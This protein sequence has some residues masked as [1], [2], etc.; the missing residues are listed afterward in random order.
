MRYCYFLFLLIALSISNGTCYAIIPGEK[1]T[2]SLDILLN[3]TQNPQKQVEGLLDLTKKNK[4]SYP[5]KAM[6]YAQHACDIAVKNHLKK[7]ELQSM[8]EVADVYKLKN[9]FVDAMSLAIKVKEVAE[10]YDFKDEL[11]SSYLTIG[12][13][14]G[15]LSQETEN[16]F[17]ALAIYEKT[18]NKKGIGDI[19]NALGCVLGQQGDYTKALQYFNIALA[20]MKEAKSTFGIVSV[21]NNV[22]NLYYFKKEYKKAI[23][24]F[25]EVLH[26]SIGM[27]LIES[28]LFCNIAA[29]YYDMGD[30]DTFLY[31]NNQAILL[32]QKFGKYSTL[33]LSYCRLADYY[34]KQKK[35]K[36]AY[37]HYLMLIYQ[38]GEK[39]KLKDRIYDATSMLNN[40]YRDENK[41]DSAYKYS[42]IEH[43]VKD[44]IGIEDSKIRF[45][46][47]EMQYQDEKKQHEA[48]L[49]QQQRD[50]L[51]LFIILLLLS[52][53][54]TAILLLSR[55][56]IK[57]KNISL[58]KKQ[59][60]DEIEFK[61][62]ELVIN[63]MSL[64]KKN[65]F[66]V[67]TSHRLLEITKELMDGNNKLR[68][69]NVIN[70][71]QKGS[72]EEIWT[73]FEARFKQ[74]HNTFYEHLIKLFPALTPNELKLCAFL[75]LNLSTKEI[76]NLTGQNAA[77]LDVARCRLRKKLELPNSTINLVS[78][79]SQI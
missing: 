70:Q 73:E 59:L 26:L 46:I 17:K 25:K 1:T 16:F 40:F 34:L 12:L 45:T 31:Y 8:L 20:Y 57:M 71:M 23:T 2:D 29:C 58:E 62:K 52:G 55:Q 65:E 56:R 61:N 69:L 21:I 47:V 60:S 42:I 24:N 44:S 64:L 53:C 27:G 41:W 30:F 72:E 18:G 5:D 28:P 48:K 68:I 15:N 77:S 7:Q 10:E 63:V 43:Q 66:I 74:V 4:Y 13:I 51:T 54:A 19:Y 6:L 32:S 67:E 37:L 38:Q 79:L 9:K 78:F 33:L 11:A 14:Q 49:K 76:C 3:A 36:S 75:R 39:Y 35:D 22:G 50:F